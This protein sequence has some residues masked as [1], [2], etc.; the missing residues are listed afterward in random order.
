MAGSFKQRRPIRYWVV[1]RTFVTFEGCS[2]EA[3]LNTGARIQQ[4]LIRC[5]EM[6]YADVALQTDQT[7]GTTSIGRLACDE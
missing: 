7:T 6:H 5:F 1:S 4:M 2:V 3:F